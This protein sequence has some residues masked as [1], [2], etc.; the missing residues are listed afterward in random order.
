[1]SVGLAVVLLSSACTDRNAAGKQLTDADPAVRSDAAIRLGQSKAKDAVDPLLKALDDRDESVRVNVIRALGEIGEP[2]VVPTILAC[3]S[4]T[5]SVVRM[6]ACQALG[7]LGDPRA[8]PALEKVLYDPDERCDGRPRSARSRA[9]LDSSAHR[10]QDESEIIRSHVVKVVESAGRG[11]RA[12]AGRR[13]GRRIRSRER[14]VGLG[15]IGDASSLQLLTRSLDDP[16]YKV[17][18]RPRTPCAVAPADPSQGR[19]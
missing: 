14:R 7:Q 17:R 5:S 1:L 8:L 9:T 3:L 15:Q 4:E 18:C 6:A 16:Y 11:G 12:Q 13:A 19:A 2:R 10:A